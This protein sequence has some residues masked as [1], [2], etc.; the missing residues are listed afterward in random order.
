M[1]D[2][3]V[4]GYVRALRAFASWLYEQEYTETT[5]LGRL[6][7][8]QVTKKTVEIL[9]DEEIAWVLAT[10]AEPSPPTRAIARSSSPCSI[11]A[12]ARQRL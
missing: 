4:N 10:L 9:T 7:A 12:S 1:S 6:K 5:V 2:H 11:P 8:P 3:S